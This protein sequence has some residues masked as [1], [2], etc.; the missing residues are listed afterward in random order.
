MA[1]KIKVLAWAIA[2]ASLL[3]A[4]PCWGDFA[5]SAEAEGSYLIR[6]ASVRD[7]RSVISA[8]SEVGVEDVHAFR[9]VPYLR[10]TIDPSNIKKVL[11]LPR[12]LDCVP[13]MP[14]ST[15]MNVSVRSMKAAP[16]PMYSPSTAH[17]LGYTGKGITIAILDGGVDNEHP[18]FE[19][20]FVAGADFTAPESP[21][22]PRD[23][24]VDPDDVEGHGTP[25]AS[26]ALGRGDGNGNFIGMAPDAGLIDLKIRKVGPTLPGP[27]TD[28]IEWCIANKDTEW[29]GGYRG[30]DVISISAGLGQVGGPVDLAIKEAV[31]SGLVVVSAATNSGTSFGDNPNNANDYWVDE[32]IIAGGT[33]TLGTVD[34]SDD[35]HWDQST[36]GPRTSD[37][38]DDPYDELKP[39]VSAPGADLTLAAHSSLSEITPATGY[40]VFSGTS[41]STPHVS[42]LAALMLEANPD[43]VPS[44]GVNPVRLILHRTSEAKGDPFNAAISDSYNLY[45]GYG[46]IDSYEAVRAAESFTVT[47]NDPDIVVFEADRPKALSGETVPFTALATDYEEQVLTYSMEAGQGEVVKDTANPRT[48]HWEAPESLGTYTFTLTVTDTTG[49]TDESSIEVEVM[50]GQ[51]NTAPEIISIDAT[52]TVISPGETTEIEVQAIDDDGDD[53]TYDFAAE[54]GTV[55]PEGSRATYTAPGTDGQDTITVTVSDTMGASDV[56][57]LTITV[58]RDVQGDPPTI[59]YVRST[60]ER[61]EAGYDGEVVITAM[62]VR[63]EFDVTTVWADLSPLGGLNRTLLRDD[64]VPPDRTAGDRTYTAAVIDLSALPEGRYEYKVTAADAAGLTSEKRGEIIVLPAGSPEGDD[65]ADMG[66][67][68]LIAAGAIAALLIIGSIVTYLTIRLTKKG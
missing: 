12:V 62:V 15:A 41:Y 39:D 36:W 8:L 45:S 5:S 17:D 54:L 34:R 22:N 14:T 7:G 20:A 52:R 61:V 11:S 26:V 10:A 6:I 2:M 46:M 47:A 68:A 65:G 29:G 42:G 43:L 32:A 49:R 57:T 66:A 55:E 24:S 58:Q 4:I 48:W 3:V 67:I 38:D 19:G 9:Y 21:L 13:E 1:G 63:N 27:M 40:G 51:T 28:A 23:G 64:G 16:S 25:V 59:E 50:E 53:L 44:E 31:S 18:T 60:P 37:G 35:I 33:E 30:V 56:S